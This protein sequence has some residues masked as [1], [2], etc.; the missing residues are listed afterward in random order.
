M[1]GAAV[2]FN[3][4]PE[5]K[6]SAAVTFGLDCARDGYEC[7]CCRRKSKAE[8]LQHILAAFGSTQ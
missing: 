2:G 4:D 6:K 8:S 3:G 7:V 1:D 5:P